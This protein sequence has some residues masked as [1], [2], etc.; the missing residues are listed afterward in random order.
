MYVEGSSLISDG[1]FHHFSNV[2]SHL[3]GKFGIQGLAIMQNETAI[4][5]K[6]QTQGN[7]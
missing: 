3:Q 6:F 1:R 4:R 2:E 7:D 5:D